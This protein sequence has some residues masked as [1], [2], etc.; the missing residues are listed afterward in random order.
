MP[1]PKEGKIRRLVE[2]KSSPAEGFDKTRA[3][4]TL[5]GLSLI[6]GTSFILIKK[7]L[8]GFS[9]TQVACLRLSISAL[10][11]VP[12]FILY[13]KRMDWSKWPY[14]VIVGLTGSG[15]PAFLFSNAQVHIS[16]AMAGIL[17]SLT[18]LFTFLLGVLFFNVRFGMSKLAGVFL[19]LAGA[20]LLILLGNEGGLSGKTAYGLLIVLAAV[21][22]ATSTNVIGKHLR[23]M[24]SI[25]ISSAS[26]GIIGIPLMIYL[27]GATDFLH[28]MAESPQAW[29]SLGFIVILSLVGTVAATAIFFR[30][31]QETS[32][33]FS[34]TVAYLMPLVALIWGLLDGEALNWLHLGGMALIL[35]GVYLSR[36]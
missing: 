18:P 2:K 21:C 10:A 17:N 16:S 13:R 33:V 24:S 11:F 7:G 30:L 28:R 31:I 4:V 23:E 5:G 6:W 35:S 3:F 9:P 8:E 27:L 12:M 36:R 26:F 22:Y 14:L 29:E 25:L 34:S 20:V 19:G 15:I 1:A 32:P